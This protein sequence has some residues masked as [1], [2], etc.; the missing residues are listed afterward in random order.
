MTKLY[1]PTRTRIGRALMS[2]WI[3]WIGLIISR[4]LDWGIPFVLGLLVRKRVGR[5]AIVTKKRLFNDILSINIVSIRAYK[6]TETHDF[7]HDL[8][9]NI[10]A[11]LPIARLLDV[12]P[13]G[14]RVELPVFG[15]L[16]ILLDKITSNDDIEERN[17]A[18]VECVKLTLTPESP[19][20]LGMREI[21]QLD[22]F[23]QYAEVIFSAAEKLCLKE[24]KLIQSYTILEVPRIDHFKEEK[25]FEFEDQDLGSSVQATPNKVTIVVSASTQISKAA[26][27]YILV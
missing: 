17:E 2:E 1:L 21:N 22:G 12:F 19:V 4:M 25:T 9:D 27:K 6:P 15:N 20:R 16:R 23:A 7:S 24:A 18:D 14:M 3:E 10:R 13:N 26:R 8:Y 11:K 5:F